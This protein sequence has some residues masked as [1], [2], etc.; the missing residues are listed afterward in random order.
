MM[1]LRWFVSQWLV[2]LTLLLYLIATWLS[3]ERAW[4]ALQSGGQLLISVSLLVLAVMGLVG[5]VQTWIS[6]DMVSRLLGEKSGPKALLVAMLCGTL[7]IGPPYIIFPLLMTIRNQGARWAVV[8]I[9][10]AAYAVKL[11]MIPLEVGFLGWPFSLGRSLL[12]LLFAVPTG[13]LV[14]RIMNSSRSR[15]P[16]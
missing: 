7:L 12:T 13:L 11:P 8:T 5:L 2:S 9:V 15:F 6:R 16:H 14:E 10:L 4:T 1:I 3:P